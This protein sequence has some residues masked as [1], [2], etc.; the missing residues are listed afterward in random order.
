L[1]LALAALTLLWPLI[2]RRGGDSRLPD[3][4]IP[5]SDTL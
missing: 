3:S 2:S 5:D 1:F 4:S